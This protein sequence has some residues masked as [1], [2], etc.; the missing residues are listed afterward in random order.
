MLFPLKVGTH[1]S[2]RP[3]SFIGPLFQPSSRFQV[4]AKLTMVAPLVIV[5]CAS[6]LHFVPQYIISPVS[7]FSEV[8]NLGVVMGSALTLKS[9]IVVI[10]AKANLRVICRCNIHLF[11]CLLHALTPP[12]H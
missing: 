8:K 2:P 4:S 9:H 5:G 11:Y 7:L 6:T 12:V 1:V 10:V 3:H